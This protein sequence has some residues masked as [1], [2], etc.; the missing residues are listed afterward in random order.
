MDHHKDAQ[1]KKYCSPPQET[2][3]YDGKGKIRRGATNPAAGAGSLT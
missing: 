3:N 2:W 1:Q